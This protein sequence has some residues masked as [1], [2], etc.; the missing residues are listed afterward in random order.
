M[1]II[2]VRHGP[3]SDPN[4]S[5]WPNDADRPLTAAGIEYARAAA[6]GI[7]RISSGVA[8]I[9]TSPYARAVETAR[10]LGETFGIAEVEVAQALSSG[11][12]TGNVLAMLASRPLDCSVILVG[13][14]PDL[15]LLTA[16]LIGVE[17]ALPL[18]KAGA[19]AIGFAG[20]P[21]AGAGHLIWYLPTRVL[22]ILGGAN[23]PDATR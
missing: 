17:R 7:A 8:A 12:A 19:C 16:T 11:S 6:R 4:T 21:R 1:R 20:A 23:T 3:A 5:R 14:E 18:D 22:N 9:L 13:H 2:L 10:I 15:G